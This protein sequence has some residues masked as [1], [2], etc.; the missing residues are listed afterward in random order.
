MFV[1]KKKK[2]NEF[3]IL[4]ELYNL[5]D[6]LFLNVK[7]FPASSYANFESFVIIIVNIIITKISNN[8]NSN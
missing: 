8:T 1:W 4:K 7:F 2:G 3:T 5:V 6:C